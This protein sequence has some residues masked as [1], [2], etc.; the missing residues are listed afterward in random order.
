[1]KMKAISLWRPWA[2]WVR[3]GWKPLETRTHGRFRSL[4]GHSIAIHA[5]QRWDNGWKTAAAKYLTHEQYIHTLHLKEQPLDGCV[6]ATAFVKE[7]R[8]INPL[9]VDAEVSAK[10]ECDTYRFG[11][12]LTNIQP[13]APFQVKGRQGIFSVEI[14]SEKDE[15][16]DH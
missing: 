9:D 2:D 12:W 14:P 16:H 13:I 11:L 1:M 15:P 10:I 7:A 5:A 3:L 6:L 8:W 4:E